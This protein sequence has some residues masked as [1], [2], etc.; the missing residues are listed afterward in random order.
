[1]TVDLRMGI[2]ARYRIQVHGAVDEAW[3]DYYDNMVVEIEAG[4]MRRPLTT[5][6]GRVI[7]QAALQAMLSLL[8]DM[9]LPLVSVEWLP[10]EEQEPRRTDPGDQ[11]PHHVAMS[12]Q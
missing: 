7:D 8:Y 9:Q 2:P 6:T 5:I 3:F 11:R 10:E 4:S 1:M 12:R